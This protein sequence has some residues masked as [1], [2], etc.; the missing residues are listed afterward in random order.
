MARKNT[1]SSRLRGIALLMT[2][3]MIGAM[4]IAPASAH[5]VPELPHLIKHMKQIFFTKA[6]ANNRFVQKGGAA[7]GDLA[8]TYPNPAIANRAV[9]NPK[10]ADGAVTQAKIANGA[11]TAAKL[12]PT[13]VV[14]FDTQTLFPADAVTTRSQSCPDGDQLLSGGLV[15][16][17]RNLRLLGSHPAFVLRL[18]EEAQRRWTVSA[19]NVSSEDIQA[20]IWVLCLIPSESLV[21]PSPGP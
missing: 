7:G 15:N 9:T 20:E 10:I 6:Q 13:R 5:F 14:I 18:G 4:M 17:N 11:V 3:L 12:G 2:G 8:G 19:H 21:R 16:S 1:T